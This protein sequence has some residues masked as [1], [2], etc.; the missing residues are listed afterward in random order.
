MGKEKGCA[1]VIAIWW[2][3]NAH[4]YLFWAS[5]IIFRTKLGLNYY[6]NNM[7]SSNCQY[8]DES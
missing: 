2:A 5:S 3:R 7:Y 1:V 6:E 4:I 8:G